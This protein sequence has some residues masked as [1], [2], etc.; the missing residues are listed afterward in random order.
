MAAIVN[1]A[2]VQA[3][4]AKPW[5]GIALAAL[6]VV[7]GDIGT[8]PLY[9]LKEAASAAGPIQP[10]TVLGILSL[11]L[12]ALVLVISVKYCTFVLKAD[13]RGEGGIIAL[14]ALLNARRVRPGTWR[15][16]LVVLGLVGTALLYGDGTITPAISVLSAVE[17]LEVYAPQLK[18]FVVPVT[19]VILIL[20]FFIQSKGTGWIGGIFG[21]VILLWFAVLAVLGIG[22][23][24]KNPGVFAAV[25]PYYAAAYVAA[26]GPATTLAVL[27]SVFLAVTGARRSMPTWAI[28]AAS[29]YAS[30]GSRWRCRRSCS[31]TSARARCSSTIRTRSRTPS[32]SSRPD[33]CTT[34]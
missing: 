18:T 14:L 24:L 25:N 26:A 12:W 29:P 3:H 21:P 9:A 13:N 32:I 30:P 23:I 10:A 33:G 17:G 19:A 2:A 7:F 6:G 20:L 28:S 22:G 1:G 8:S 15:A 31:I 34:R 16:Y 11:I 27:A 4:E 5:A